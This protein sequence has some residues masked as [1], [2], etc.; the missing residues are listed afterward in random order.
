MEGEIRATLKSL[1]EKVDL[2]ISAVLGN[3][4]VGLMIRVDRLEQNEKS[5]KDLDIRLDR[6]ERRSGFLNKFMWLTVSGAVI[7]L[8]TALVAATYQ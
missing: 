1:E 3:G 5:R 2:L 7:A 8:I 4:H 6:M